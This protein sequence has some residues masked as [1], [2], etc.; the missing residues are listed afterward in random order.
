MRTRKA[1]D[2][3]EKRLGPLTFGGFLKSC[4]TSQDMSQTEMA[5][6]LGIG[7][8]TVCDMEKGRQGVSPKLAG[9][10]AH[11]CGLS[12]E[13][14]VELAVKDLLKRSGLNFDSVQI[15]GVKRASG[16]WSP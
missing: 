4:R 9:E 14:A 13:L 6:F 12:M 15:S 11:K 1:K 7:R 2:I 8:S 5:K 10:I 3:L 16:E